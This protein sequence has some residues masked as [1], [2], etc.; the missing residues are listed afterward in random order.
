M[1]HVSYFCSSDNY[2]MVFQ[3]Y[4]V[5]FSLI[6]II[7]VTI[8][9]NVL[10]FTNIIGRL[11][12]K[13]I[14]FYGKDLNWHLVY[15]YLYRENIEFFVYDVDVPKKNISSVVRRQ[16]YIIRHVLDKMKINNIDMSLEDFTALY[17]R[18]NNNA[19]HFSQDRYDYYHSS[20][21]GL[22]RPMLSVE[23]VAYLLN[24]GADMDK[25]SLLYKRGL[26]FNEIV[27]V[28]EAPDNWI[29]VLK[30]SAEFQRIDHF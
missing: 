10:S 23:Q 27:E 15:P 24:E 13:R 1:K 4:V 25:V 3:D 22:N 21:N 18:V 14:D 19:I 7:L 12:C 16:K 29:N 2:S 6:F 9:F 20:N 26:S 30:P 28:Y 11:E 5:V 17:L 8:L